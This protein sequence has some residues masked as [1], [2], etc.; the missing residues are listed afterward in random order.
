MPGFCQGFEDE[1]PE[2]VGTIASRIEKDG[3]KEDKG[4][5]DSAVISVSLCVRPL[6]PV[7]ASPKGTHRVATNSKMA[8]DQDQASTLEETYNKHNVSFSNPKATIYKG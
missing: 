3:A 8:S 4:G 2:V 7:W 6:S 1:L 5:S